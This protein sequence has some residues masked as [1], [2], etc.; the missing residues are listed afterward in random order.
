[1]SGIDVEKLGAAIF[2]AHGPGYQNQSVSIHMA[3]WPSFF[4]LSLI[5]LS[6]GSAPKT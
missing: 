3:P 6:L 5:L 2:V 4:L 1:M